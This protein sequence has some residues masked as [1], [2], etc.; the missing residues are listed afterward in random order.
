VNKNRK[1]TVRLSVF[2]TFFGLVGSGLAFATIP[3]NNVIDGCYRKSGGALR[4]I[5]GT[6]TKC[7]SQE[8]ALAWNVQGVKGDKGDKG[9][10]GD[11]GIQGIQG[12]QGLKG[13]KGDTGAPGATGATGAPGP[14]WTV[15]SK[16]VDGTVPATTIVKNITR[17]CN[18]GDIALSGGFDVTIPQAVEVTRSERLDGDSWVFDVLNT[19]SSS[20]ATIGLSVVCADPTP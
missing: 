14:S 18:T 13:D 16:N 3:S 4:V 6:V 17:D 9:D 10:Q 11:Q 15:Y 1:R 20:T 8:T 5:D 7:S 12:V 19:D 2:V